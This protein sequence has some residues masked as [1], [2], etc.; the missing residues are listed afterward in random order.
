MHF[1]KNTASRKMRQFIGSIP[2]LG[3]TH[4]IIPLMT[5]TQ[6]TACTTKQ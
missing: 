3:A 2:F 1:E 5:L 6:L 4:I